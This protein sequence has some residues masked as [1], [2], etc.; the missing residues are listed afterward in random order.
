MEESA[1]HIGDQ[2]YPIEEMIGPSDYIAIP[3]DGFARFFALSLTNEMR[4]IDIDLEQAQLIADQSWELATTESAPFA[5]AQADADASVAGPELIIFSATLP[6]GGEVRV[7]YGAGAGDPDS[8]ASQAS[9]VPLR[10]RKIVVGQLDQ[11]PQHELLV[12]PFPATEL[13]RVDVTEQGLVTTSIE[14]GQLLMD[15]ATGDVDGDG[16]DEILGLD[17]SAERVVLID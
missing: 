12:V 5:L 2:T 13:V 17:V 8:F 6:D 4:I 1:L 9:Q 16:V 14:G 3:G 15:V 7:F 10:S 11:D